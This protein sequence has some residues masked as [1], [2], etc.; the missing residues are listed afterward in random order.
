MAE[1]VGFQKMARLSRDCVV[2]EKIDGTNA[3]VY[4]VEQDGFHLSDALY[5]SDG[6]ALFAG[7][8]KR[9]VYPESDNFGFA[10]WCVD[11][12]DELLELGPGRHFGEWWGQGIQRHYGLTERRFS[13]F[14]TIR[15]CLHDAEPERIVTG[16]PRQEKYQ[17]R[18][19][20]CCGLVPVLY[21][22]PF[23]TE[24]IDCILDSLEVQGS[25][26]VDGFMNP[27]G[28]VVYHIAANTAFKKTLGDDGH[29]G[30]KL[31]S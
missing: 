13:L 31:T 5:Q 18:V 20:A 30:T 29:K 28:I 24:T 9:W 16:D 10:G 15:W 12:G 19:P 1:F 6:L 14:N 11:H 27:E 17:E 22:G 4:I 7:S 21:R 23:D 2:S 8:R 25:A 26:A 3:Q